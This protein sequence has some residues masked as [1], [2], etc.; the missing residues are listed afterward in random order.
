[1]TVPS[2]TIKVHYSGDGVQTGFTGTWTA[3]AD[4][5]PRVIITDDATGVET[6]QVLNSDYTISGVGQSQFTVTMATAP[7]VGKTLTIVSDRP[8]TQLDDYKQ[9]GQLNMEALEET[10]DKVAQ[11][12][13]QLKEASD[14]TL[15]LAVS[16][17]SGASTEIPAPVAGRLLGWNAA[18]DELENKTPAD[19]DLATVTAFV[20]TLLD[21]ADAATFLATLG[22]SAFIQTLLDDADAAAALTTLGAAALTGGNTVTGVQ[23]LTGATLSI[24]TPSADAEATPKSY[25]DGTVLDLA[26]GS[27]VINGGAVIAQGAAGNLAAGTDVYSSADSWIINADFGTVT[28]GTASRSSTGTPR[29]GFAAEADGVQASGGTQQIIFKSRVPSEF[30]KDLRG[31]NVSLKAKAIHTFASAVGVT[32]KLFYANSV[33]DFSS[34]TEIATWDSITALAASTYDTLEG[35]LTALPTEAAQ[36]LEVQIIFDVGADIPAATDFRVSDLTLVSGDLA[37]DYVCDYQRELA[38][39]LLFYREIGFVAGIVTAAD[40][41]YLNTGLIDMYSTPVATLLD[42]TPRIYAPG[43]S[44]GSGSAIISSTLTSAGCRIAIDG[45]SGLSAGNGCVSAQNGIFSLDARL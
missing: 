20:E 35:T 7:A 5:D 22:V 9:Q 13:L 43:S 40:T 17:E 15:R 24:A 25:V 29:G 38:R 18:G 44:Y 34:V 14:R 41:I 2:E 42:T 23:N 30:C 31:L 39:C 16:D 37:A 32:A 11:N 26:N 3:H 36:G 45:F 33:D 10:F 27:R 21:D 1:M 6:D 28:A 4:S 19:L 12:V 8:Y